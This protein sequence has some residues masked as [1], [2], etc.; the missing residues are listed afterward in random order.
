MGEETEEGPSGDWEAGSCSTKW[1]LKTL[2]ILIKWVWGEVEIRISNKLWGD[3]R[4]ADP[5]TSLR[6]AR[7]YGKEDWMK[8]G[9]LGL[10]GQ[11]GSLLPQGTLAQQAHLSEPQLPHLEAWFRHTHLL[12]F[13]R[14]RE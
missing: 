4:A 6:M 9:R 13:Q 1:L 10:E 12:G 14:S 11:A 7:P 2:Q 3:A 8:M 5:W